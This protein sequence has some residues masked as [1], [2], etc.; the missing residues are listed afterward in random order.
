MRAA[1]PLLWHFRKF[2]YPN[3]LPFLDG[4]DNVA[5]VLDLA[6]MSA[7][8]ARKRAIELL[9][10]LEVGHRKHALPK[11]LSGGGGATGRDSARAR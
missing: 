1:L 2:Q 6:G 10:Y 11:Q 5:V 8:P 3:L 7:A 9:D 4:S